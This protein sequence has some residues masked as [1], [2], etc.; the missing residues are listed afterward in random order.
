MI[1][2]VG[3]KVDGSVA[4]FGSAA[5][6]DTSTNMTRVDRGVWLID[7]KDPSYAGTDVTYPFV[8]TN[9][10]HKLKQFDISN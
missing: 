5:R 3:E 1:L 2:V 6:T 8:L 4:T 7:N 9:V 10:K